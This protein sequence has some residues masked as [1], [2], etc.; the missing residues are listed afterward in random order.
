MISNESNNEF[1]REMTLAERRAF[2]QLPL[3][4]RRRLL[5]LQAERM[6]ADYEDAAATEARLE[7][8]GGDIVELNP[9]RER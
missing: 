4:E 7:W 3:A 2:L 5:A 8:Q 6:I 9:N 1:E